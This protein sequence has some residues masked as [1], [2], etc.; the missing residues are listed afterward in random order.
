MM[1]HRGIFRV[2]Q[3]SEDSVDIK[4]VPATFKAKDNFDALINDDSIMSFPFG[5]GCL[6]ISYS[7][8]ERPILSSL[9]YF[10][11][12]SLGES[13][14][15]S[16]GTYHM[17]CATLCFCARLLGHK[18][19]KYGV[20]DDATFWC[21]K[22]KVNMWLHN[23]LVYGET[24]YERK[25]GGKPMVAEDVADDVIEAWSNTKTKLATEHVKRDLV[26]SLSRKTRRDLGNSP[27]GNDLCAIMES[28]VGSCT[29]QEM[30]TQVHFAHDGDGCKLFSMDNLRK[31]QQYFNIQRVRTFEIELTAK[32]YVS[33][34]AHEKVLDG[35]E[36]L[37]VTTEQ[38]R[39][40]QAEQ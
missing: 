4:V 40:H 2:D 24:Y 12:C 36:L 22:K 19:N 16:T 14:N 27:L 9:D 3:K 37:L 23:L 34:V 20:Q 18:F 38:V 8:R 11:N 6:H 5:S 32:H 33:L 7:G 29:W 26:D 28:C 13:M 31:I 39:S 15:R 17:V 30:F 1:L 10:Q 35:E 25:F 21:G